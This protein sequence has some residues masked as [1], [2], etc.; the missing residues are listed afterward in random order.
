LR[1]EQ[2]GAG[3]SPGIFFKKGKKKRKKEKIDFPL[4]SV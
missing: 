4:T 3:G 2:K 1:T